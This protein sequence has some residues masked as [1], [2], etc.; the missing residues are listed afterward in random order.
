MSEL[1]T[2]EQDTDSEDEESDDDE[3]GT[4][5]EPTDGVE[6]VSQ[7][8]L[9]D[10]VLEQVGS[11]QHDIQEE[12]EEEEEEERVYAVEPVQVRTN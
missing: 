4:D 11:L 9:V 12:D 7:E 10:H 6:S 8:N 1:E 3:S 2:V 5:D